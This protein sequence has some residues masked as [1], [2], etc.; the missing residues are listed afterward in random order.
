MCLSTITNMN[1]QLL[2]D[3]AESYDGCIFCVTLKKNEI[4]I[5]MNID[6]YVR[7]LEESGNACSL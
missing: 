5:V 1:M 2:Y 7:V 3:F 4:G 6:G